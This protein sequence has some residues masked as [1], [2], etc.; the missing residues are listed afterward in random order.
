MKGDLKIMKRITLLLLVI[1]TLISFASIV[2]AKDQLVIQIW[3]GSFQEVYEKYIIKP[4]EE[5]YDVDVVVATGVEWFTLPKILAEVKSGRPEID[6]VQLTVSDYMRGA[7]MN[8]WEKLDFANIP[9]YENVPDKYRAPYGIGFE[10]YAMGLLYNK[11]SKEPK[12]SSIEASWDPKYKV[13]VS[14]THDQYIIPMVNHMITGQF[15]PVDVDAVFKKLDELKPNIVTFNVSHAEIRNLIA[16]NE[17]DLTTAFNNRA[18][19]MIDDGLDVE[20][21]SGPHDFIGVDYWA[22]VKG[23]SKKEL[24]E[25]FINFTLA[26][27]QQTVNA[28]KQYLGPVNKIVVLDKEFVETRGVPYGNVL[29]KAMT[30]DDYKYIAENLD[31]WSNRWIKW[32][33]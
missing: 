21:I 18:G 28:K 3:P 15:T 26:K 24:A 23:T 10:T 22:I 11:K 1:V 19:L 29:E 9:E 6:I 12:P 17:I 31:K 33:D 5:K 32:L 2:E 4:F 7:N 20:F 14:T 25:K 8:L 30:M 27:E 16:N 13:T